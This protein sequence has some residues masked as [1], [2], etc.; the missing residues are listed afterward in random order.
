MS[1]SDRVARRTPG[2]TGADLC[3]LLKRGGDP[4]GRRQLTEVAIG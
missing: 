3:N 4:G 2:Y 1:I